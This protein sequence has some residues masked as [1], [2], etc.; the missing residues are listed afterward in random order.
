M[1]KQNLDIA[2]FVSFCIEQYKTSKNLNGEQAL[3]ELQ[4]YGVIEYLESNFEPLHTQSRQWILEDI[5]E[6]I[7]LRRS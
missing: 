3:A 4:K 5:D 2:Y 7:N 6:F 1:S